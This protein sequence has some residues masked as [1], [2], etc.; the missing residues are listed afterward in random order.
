MSYAPSGKLTT[1]K[2]EVA[3]SETWDTQTEWEAFQSQDN[4]DISNGTLMLAPPAIPTDGLIHRYRFND[5]SDSTT[6]IDSEGSNNG[7]INGA[8]YTTNAQEGA[9]AISFDGTDDNV[10][11]GT[12]VITSGMSFSVCLWVE[13]ASLASD[14]RIFTTRSDVSTLLSQ[15]RT[16]SDSVDLFAD[17]TD[18]QLGTVTSGTDYHLAYTYD[19]PN[20]V[21]TGYLDGEQVR[22]ENHDVGSPSNSMTGYGSNSAQNGNFLDGI[23][24]DSLIYNR[25]LSADEVKEIYLTY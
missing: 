6:A 13:F 22:S 23:V 24:D 5:D 12:G 19:D 9:N 16:A 8:T 11:L 1:D 14:Q 18:Y 20:S 3:V 17:G 10:D 25:E 7:T 21:L 2:R 15:G 4:I